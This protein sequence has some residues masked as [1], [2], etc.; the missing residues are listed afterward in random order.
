[1]AKSGQRAH[2][3]L[4]TR[5]GTSQ[6]INTGDALLILPF[7]ALTHSPSSPQ[8][9]GHLLECLTRR[10]LL[11]ANGQALEH[12]LDLSCEQRQRQGSAWSDYLGVA[13]GK[14]GQFFALPIEGAA[15][16]AGLPPEQ[17]R[18]IGDAAARLGI[19]YQILD[20]LSDLHGALHGD[21]ESNDIR[22]GRPTAPEVQT[23]TSTPCW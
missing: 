3:A 8:M 15:L 16:V 13:D 2:P 22:Q 14:S 6:A 23:T 9:L 4:W 17:A 19:L 10:A 12:D 1:M 21:P 5:C 11:T 18:S 20:D 7:A